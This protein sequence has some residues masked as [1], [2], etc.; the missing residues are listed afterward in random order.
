LHLHIVL[1]RISLAQ[2]K[3]WTPL[4][5]LVWYLGRSPCLWKTSRILDCS[6]TISVT[7]FIMTSSWI[8]K[9][10]D[11][12]RLSR[13]CGLPYWKRAFPVSVIRRP[14]LKNTSCWVRKRLRSSFEFHMFPIVTCRPSLYVIMRPFLLSLIV[15]RRSVHQQG[16]KIC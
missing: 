12:R 3:T 15:H 6:Q 2:A 8:P 9:R 16:H 14:S 10:G 11:E 7:I 5:W 13:N 4:V 1:H